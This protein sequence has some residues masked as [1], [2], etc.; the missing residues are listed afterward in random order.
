MWLALTERGLTTNTLWALGSDVAQI[1]FTLSS[2]YLLSRFLGPSQFG[3]YT[4]AMAVSTLAALIGAAGSQQLLMLDLANGHAFEHLWSR[5]VCTVTVAGLIVTALVTG[6]RPLVLPELSLAPFILIVASH[7]VFFSLSEFAIVSAQAHRKMSVALVVRLVSGTCRLAAVLLLLSFGQP[8]VSSLAA[9]LSAAWLIAAAGSITIVRINF[10]SWP[11]WTT[12]K[13]R[14]VRR[15]LPYVIGSGTSTLLSDADRIML[16]RLGGPEATGELA[17]YGIGYR[18]STYAGIPISSLVRASDLDFFEAGAAGKQ[19]VVALAR[20]LSLIAGGYGLLA[21]IGLYAVSE[22]IALLL[23]EDFAATSSVVRFLAFLPLLKALQIF[24][25]NALTGSGQ[26]AHRNQAL[27]V[28]MV[29]NLAANSLLIPVYGWRGA[30]IST[31]CAES[32]L[33]FLLWASLLLIH[34][35]SAVKS[36]PKES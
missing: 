5:L 19:S 7:V 14:E 32:V 3:I 13:V 18:L 26:Q 25:A 34:D 4:G 20:R 23:S 1:V 33:I 27:V 17:V 36:A 35:G 15:G 30:A 28:A 24:P 21:A 12:P 22:P 2:I 6:I 8:T 31:L 29:L 10:G 16:I 9:F 11:S